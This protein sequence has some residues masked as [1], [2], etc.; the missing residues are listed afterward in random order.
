MLR[1]LPQLPLRNAF[2]VLHLRFPNIVAFLHSSTSL[3]DCKSQIIPPI[4]F[5]LND[6]DLEETF[7]HGW[8]PGGQAINKTANCVR[9]KHIPTGISVKCQDSRDLQQN[10]IIARRRLVELLDE[11]FNG[12][13]SAVAQRRKEAQVKENNRFSRAKRRLEMKT[14]FKKKCLHEEDK[15]P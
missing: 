11:H 12:E 6:N 1:Q 9:L 15:F 14:A 5:R 2:S 4:S 3:G 10:R 7:I 13:E 8:G